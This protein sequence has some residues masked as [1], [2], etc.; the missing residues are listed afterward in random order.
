MLFRRNKEM[1]HFSGRRQTKMGILSTVIGVIDVLGFLIISI[2]SGF[3]GGKGGF[4]I[5][6]TG[7]IL[8]V[9][10][11]TGFVVSYKSFKKK[12]IFYG[13]PIAGAVINGLMII[14]LFALYLLGL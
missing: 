13:F 8:L 12:D 6:I 4:I 7:I 10:S 2:I 9:L 1:I 14:I 3:A 5:G 11:V